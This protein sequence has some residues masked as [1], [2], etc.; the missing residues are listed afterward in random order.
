MMRILYVS[1]Y[2]G[3]AYGGTSRVV[4][5]LARSTGSLDLQIDIATTNAND[6]ETLG[7]R[8]NSWI[9]KKNHRI[10]YFN[11]WHKRDLVISTSLAWWLMNNIKNYDLVHTHT[12]FSPLISFAHRLCQFHQV[13]YIVTPHGMFDPWA[14][15]YKAWKK[16]F[17]Y[18]RFEKKLL[19]RASAIQVLSTSE[20]SQI[21]KLSFKK[22]VLVPNGI[23]RR[24]FETLP[25]P[26]LFYQHFPHLE[27]K[28]IILFLGRIDPKKGLDLL[29]PAFSKAYSAYPN[30]HLAIAGP[31]S[32][33]FTPTVQCYFKDVGCLEAVTFTGML[34]GTLKYA[35][36]AAA[37][38]YVSPSYSEGFSMSVL[39]GMA[40][41][42]PC[43]ITENCNFPEAQQAKAACVVPASSQAI[44]EALVTYLENPERAARMASLAQNFVFQNYTWQESANKLTNAYRE[45]LEA[46]LSQPRNISIK[47]A[48]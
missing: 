22:T 48:R 37:D 7:V 29:A 42:L 1:P 10:Q 36:L 5:E 18:E 32:T 19:D 41:K 14:L 2:L 27:T 46:S 17:Y 16:R 28:K 31:D 4:T 20:Q 39:E 11:T 15:S 38:L 33:N 40:A 25:D 44:G 3:A 8:I 21:T 35:A 12:L 6:L 45:I 9:S 13:P 43:I 26:T 30:I 47:N 34:S 24:E 23:H